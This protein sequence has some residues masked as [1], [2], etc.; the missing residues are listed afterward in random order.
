M[1]PE[2]Q[3]STLT[4]PIGAEIKPDT[5]NW[6][7]K[8]VMMNDCVPPKKES[9][10]IGLIRQQRRRARKQTSTRSFTHTQLT[11]YSIRAL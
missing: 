10:G 9:A 6:L 4:T 8:K 3:C 11:Y 1:C 5:T 7:I 2:V